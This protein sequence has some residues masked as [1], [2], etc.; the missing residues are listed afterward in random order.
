MIDILERMLKE[1]AWP[2]L[3]HYHSICLKGLRK[4]TENLSQDIW[5]LGWKFEPRTSLIQSSTL[6][7]STIMFSSIHLIDAENMVMNCIISYTL[8]ISPMLSGSTVTTAWRVLG[9]RV[10]ETASSYGG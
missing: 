2:T 10:E 9:L 8:G 1:A 6:N 3:R 4:T 5:F 7:H